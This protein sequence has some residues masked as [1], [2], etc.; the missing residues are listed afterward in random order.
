MD[1]DEIVNDLIESGEGPKDFLNRNQDV[2]A[3]TPHGTV[4]ANI[5]GFNIGEAAYR[6]G[7][8]FSVKASSRREAVAI[9]NDFIHRQFYGNSSGGANYLNHAHGGIVHFRVYVDDDMIV[10]DSDIISEEPYADTI[11]RGGK[12]IPANE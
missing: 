3:P 5:Y 8:A 4:P 11:V 6:V 12:R 2:H 7:I 1:A 9:A 10:T